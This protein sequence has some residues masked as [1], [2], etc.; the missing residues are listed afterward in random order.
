MDNASITQL[1]SITSSATAEGKLYYPS[2]YYA[3]CG[4]NL[5]HTTVSSSMYLGGK[6]CHPLGVPSSVF[7]TSSHCPHSVVGGGAHWEKN[8]SQWE[9]GG[10]FFKMPQSLSQGAEIFCAWLFLTN[11]QIFM[12]R[13]WIFSPIS[14]QQDVR[15]HS[16]SLGATDKIPFS[17]VFAFKGQF[18]VCIHTFKHFQPIKTILKAKN[19]H[20][21]FGIRTLDLFYTNF[22]Y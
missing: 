4:A 14:A 13:F 18:Y 20:G 16:V 5:A 7:V 17:Q 11:T 15:Y 2:K 8:R 21:K 12:L 1:H 9:I 22:A 19:Q 10:R 6:C 3:Q